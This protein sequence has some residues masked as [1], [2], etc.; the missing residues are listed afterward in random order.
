MSA[1]EAATPGH[2]GEVRRVLFDALDPE[3]VEQLGKISEALLGALDPEDS[4]PRYTPGHD[5]WR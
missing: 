3:Q 4:E 5:T 1:L 2:A